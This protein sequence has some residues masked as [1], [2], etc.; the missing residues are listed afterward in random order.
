MVQ[1]K[2]EMNQPDLK[3]KSFVEFLLAL[4]ENRLMDDHGNAII[5]ERKKKP[6][7]QDGSR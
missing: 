1:E 6:K 7:W 2:Q 4:E 5:G 3:E